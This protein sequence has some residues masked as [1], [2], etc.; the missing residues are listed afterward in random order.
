MYKK[1]VH[2][3]WL[4]IILSI[5]IFFLFILIL[6]L[7]VTV[8]LETY[9]DAL[10]RYEGED[11]YLYNVTPEELPSNQVTINFNYNDKLYSYAVEAK[12]VEGTLISVDNE[13]LKFFLTQNNIAELRVSI[14]MNDITVLNYIFSL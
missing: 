1:W 11:L 5:I 8:K 7:V 3:Y 2:S 4:E 9:K 6:Y 10:L 12:R 14:K 13:A